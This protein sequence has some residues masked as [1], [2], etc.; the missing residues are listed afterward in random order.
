MAVAIAVSSP[1]LQRGSS[2]LSYITPDI[3]LVPEPK[4]YDEDAF[5]KAVAKESA[6]I[7]QSGGELVSQGHQNMA[8]FLAQQL[9]DY[10]ARAD[11]PKPQLIATSEQ[12]RLHISIL[13][14]AG[15]KF[16]L[17]D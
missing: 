1:E 3:Q 4:V 6:R 15:V 17:T 9:T 7:H 16:S 5:N 13:E 12:L 11:V 2:E 10:E 8:R 14:S